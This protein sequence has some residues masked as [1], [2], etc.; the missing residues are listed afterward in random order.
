MTRIA[1]RRTEEST[2]K[3]ASELIVAANFF[4]IDAQNTQRIA[5]L[6]GLNTASWTILWSRLV[7][8][9]ARHDASALGGQLQKPDLAVLTDLRDRLP[10]D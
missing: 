6:H 9:R 1:V 3:L 8:W 10:I 5:P 7:Y 2:Q 4:T